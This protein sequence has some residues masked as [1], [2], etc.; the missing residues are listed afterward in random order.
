MNVRSLEIL[1]VVVCVALLLF[2]GFDFFWPKPEIPAIEIR[3]KV[4]VDDAGNQRTNPDGSLLVRCNP[5][6]APCVRF[7]PKGF[8]PDTAAPCDPENPP[9]WAD[10]IDHT[11]PTSCRKA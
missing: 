6:M 5:P 10:G 2:V 11:P 8:D 9:P 7:F 1:F 4:L 3:C